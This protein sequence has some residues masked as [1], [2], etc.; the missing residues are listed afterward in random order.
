MST[1]VH[2]TTLAACAAA[3]T[4][5]G[6]AAPAVA[7]ATATDDASAAASAT[8]PGI[9]AHTLEKRDEAVSYWTPERMRQ[10]KDKSKQLPRQAKPGK[11]GKLEK[12][13]TPQ[14]ITGQS[15]TRMAASETPRPTIGKVFF[16]M[17]GTDYVCSANAVTASNRSVV[18]T[19]GHCVNEGPGG[20]AQRFVFVPAYE[21]GRS[22]YGRWSGV[23][24]FTPTEWS[25]RGDMN[26]DVAFVVVSRLNGAALSDRVGATGVS[27]NQARGLTYAAYGY[28]AAAPFNGETLK[29]CRGTAFKNP[30]NSTSTSQG[31]PCDMTG[32]SSGGPWFIGNGYSGN[33]SVQN[34]VNSFGYPSLGDYMFGP[35]F[36][37]T[38]QRAYQGAS[39]AS[40]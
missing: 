37:P 7:Q 20:Y 18:A 35:Y 13:G 10:A 26:H 30:V 17:G 16:T 36:G 21:N 27:F 8:P 39:T 28:P 12:P 24:A 31:I 15:P 40:N 9:D 29:S 22:P 11:T 6:L 23:R 5:A 33:S 38:A 19:A 4:M 34:S 1:I 3:I 14:T 25:G 2:R 32:G